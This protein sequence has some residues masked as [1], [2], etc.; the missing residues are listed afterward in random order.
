MFGRIG[1]AFSHLFE[2]PND[3]YTLLSQIPIGCS[4]LNQQNCELIWWYSDMVRGQV[5]TITYLKSSTG[6]TP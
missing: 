2:I 6:Q 5:Y 1:I 4:S 3:A